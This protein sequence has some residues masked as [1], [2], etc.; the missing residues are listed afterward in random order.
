MAGNDAALAEAC[1]SS[2]GKET[3]N[4]THQYYTSHYESPPQMHDLGA[5]LDARVLNYTFEGE[6]PMDTLLCHSA[7]CKVMMRP[8]TAR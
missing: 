6:Q 3:H 2:L 5:L 1:A 4:S 7:K 8:S